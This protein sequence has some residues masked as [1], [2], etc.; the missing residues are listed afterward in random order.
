MYR[1]ML[2]LKYSTKR[3]IQVAGT[4]A[5]KG[6]FRVVT[7]NASAEN[8]KTLVDMVLNDVKDKYLIEHVGNCSC[9][10]YLRTKINHSTKA[11]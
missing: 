9:K 1:F 3:L 2:H 11:F 5:P 7:V 8:S 10:Y 6:P 4:M